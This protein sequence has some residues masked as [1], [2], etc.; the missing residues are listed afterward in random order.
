MY[1]NKPSFANAYSEILENI[2]L[3]I[4]GEPDDFIIGSGTDELV[5]YYYAP[6]ALIPIK[7]DHERQE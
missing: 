5:E 7:I 6:K 1:L 4:L 2:R 3:K